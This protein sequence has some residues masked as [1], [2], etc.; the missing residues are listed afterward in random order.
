MFVVANKKYR[1]QI[2]KIHDTFI[3]FVLG[4]TLTDT[5]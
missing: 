2:E 5:L 4:D 1:K 3:I